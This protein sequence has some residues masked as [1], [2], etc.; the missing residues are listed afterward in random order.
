MVTPRFGDVSVTL[1]G[2]DTSP[3]VS[4]E[5]PERS[6]KHELIGRPPTVQ[7]LGPGNDIIRVRG[8]CAE[9]TTDRL[10]E[11]RGEISVRTDRWQGV[12]FVKNTTTE[13]L[14]KRYDGQRVHKYSLRLLEVQ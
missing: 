1:Y 14:E 3:L 13:P 7:D 9:D 2:Q 11:L 5:S 10:D 6:V 8:E 12:A 4:I